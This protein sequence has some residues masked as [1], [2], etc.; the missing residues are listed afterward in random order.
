MAVGAVVVVAWVVASGR[1]SYVVQIDYNWARDF[2][3]G[4]VVEIDGDSVGVLRRYGRSQYVTGFEVEAGAH[5]VRVLHS[6]CEG[7]AEPV[8]LDPR[9]AR[10]ATLFADVDDGYR[11]RVILR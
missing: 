6:D 4:S 5:S 2:L 7:V 10:I 1:T 3:E 8:T 9:G 11:C